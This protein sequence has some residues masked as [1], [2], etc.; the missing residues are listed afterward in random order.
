MV[1]GSLFTVY[2]LR[3]GTTVEVE[4]A[5]PTL[6]YYT[7]LYYTVANKSILVSRVSVHYTVV[8]GGGGGGGGGARNNTCG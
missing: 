2:G 6:L 8:G 1:H 7:I 4:S 3:C 5:M